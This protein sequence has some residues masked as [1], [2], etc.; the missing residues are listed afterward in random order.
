METD[1]VVRR[2]SDAMQE[3]FRRLTSLATGIGILALLIGGATFATGLWAFERSRPSWTVI[4]G[5]ICIIP[6]LAAL[7]GRHLV[8][9]TAKR[10]PEL[11]ADVRRFLDTSVKSAE[12][13]ID[14]DSKQPI[15]SYVK[16]F[17]TLR[18]DL[19]ERRKELPALFSGVKAITSVP[20]IAALAVVGMCLVGILG[21]VLLIGGL[22]K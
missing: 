6:L 21:T 10:S 7:V 20:G 1:V 11:V 4:G 22:L 2:V 19:N 18:S 9:R 13:L 8:R 5:V 14:H 17:G 15:A 12:V 3:T 16:S